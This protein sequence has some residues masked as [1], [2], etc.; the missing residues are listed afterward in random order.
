LGKFFISYN[1]GV[2]MMMEKLLNGMAK[3]FSYLAELVLVSTILLALTWVMGL[4]LGLETLCCV[5]IEPE[6]AGGCALVILL[7]I[8]VVTIMADAPEE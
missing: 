7:S 8:F 4:D 1:E 5:C 2:I 3:A 6:F